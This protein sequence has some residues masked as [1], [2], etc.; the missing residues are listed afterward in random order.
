M[1]RRSFI[2]GS[3]LLLGARVPAF[4]DAKRI[5]SSAN[6]FRAYGPSGDL[7]FWADLGEPDVI[8][9]YGTV[10][11]SFGDVVFR[12][13]DDDVKIISRVTMSV[14][15]PEINQRIE[16]EA[17]FLGRDKVKVGFLDVATFSDVCCTLL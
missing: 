5:P 2:V 17:G 14:H 15:I 7:V 9:G 10:E 3:I 12:N 6:V 8:A 11:M 16:R 4:S 13:T 1:H